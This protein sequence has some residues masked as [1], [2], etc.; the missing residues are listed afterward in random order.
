VPNLHV[1]D[2]EVVGAV[3]LNDHGRAFVQRRSAGRRLFP[4]CWDIV[5]G[6]VDPG[7]TPAEA[8]ERELIEETGWQLREIVRSLGEFS[9]LGSDG[10]RRHEQDFLV[11]V[12]GDLQAP[13]LEWDKH[14]E[15]RWIGVDE[16]DV[17]LEHRS[18]NDDALRRILAAAFG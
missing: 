9:W 18:P 4:N 1:A 12:D 13:A 6:H 16:L 5:G 14:P 10:M 3:I 11:T 15:Y 17:M 7:E 8:L 2:A